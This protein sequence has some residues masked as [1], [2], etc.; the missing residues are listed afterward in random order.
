MSEHTHEST[1]AASPT[2]FALQGLEG[3]HLPQNIAPT[4]E[5]APQ[6]PQSAAPAWKSALQGPQN[7]APAMKSAHRGS[8][9]AAPPCPAKAIRSKGTSKRQHQDA[10]R[11]FRS[12]L[13][14]IPEHEP[15]VQKSRLSA[16]ATKSEHA[17]DHHHLQGTAPATE[18]AHGHEAAP[19]SCTWHEKS[20]NHKVFL[21]PVTDH[22]ERSLEEHP[23]Q[24]TRFCEPAQPECI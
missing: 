18:S 2:K 15:V 21:V 13:P 4:T 22:Q 10:K 24:P 7:I 19:I 11:S 16:P 12:R 9:R 5:S 8:H 3:L 20:A 23:R 1:F 17:E 6:G 14:P